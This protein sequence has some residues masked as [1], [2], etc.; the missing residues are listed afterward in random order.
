MSIMLNIQTTKLVDQGGDINQI[1]EVDQEATGI[2]F[3]IIEATET[4]HRIVINKQN[5]NQ[6]KIQLKLMEQHLHALYVVLC[7]IGRK[8][9][10]IRMKI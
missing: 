10:L 1:I 3:L 2:S 4:P 7:T 6:R 8:I 9:V 5:I